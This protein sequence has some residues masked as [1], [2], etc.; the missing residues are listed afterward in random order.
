MSAIIKKKSNNAMNIPASGHSLL[1]KL[2][3]KDCLKIMILKARQRVKQ[4]IVNFFKLYPILKDKKE[5]LIKKIIEQRTKSAIKIQRY[6]KLHLKRKA[7]FSFANK[8]QNYYSLYPSK[9]AKKK[10]SIK[11][12]TNPKDI[13]SFKVLQVRFCRYRQVY[14]FD[15]PKSKFP[16]LKK[17][18]RFKFIIDG[19]VILDPKYKLIRF[20]ENE[21]VN[22]VDFN[23]YEQKQKMLQ[24]KM[25]NALRKKPFKSLKVKTK[26]ISNN[27]NE[28]ESKVSEIIDDKGNNF[29]K[30]NISTSQMFRRPF[31]TTRNINKIG[32]IFLYSSREKNVSDS[33]NENNDYEIRNRN[34]SILRKNGSRSKRLKSISIDKKLSKKVS[35]GFVKF[36][37]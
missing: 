37:Y 12:Y 17:Y 9:E 7:F 2:N 4:S 32:N 13:N 10:I 14:V 16:S 3:K 25:E 1:S 26:I 27:Y 15:I 33:E 20:G 21:Y 35:F 31:L 24:I 11:L 29:R 22:E 23:E 34:R 36:S 8:Y 5:Q 6:F 30:L 19:T 28:E 18:L